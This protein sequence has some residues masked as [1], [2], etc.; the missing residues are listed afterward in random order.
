MVLSLRADI[1][2]PS[3]ITPDLLMHITSVFE[4]ANSDVTTG[5]KLSR[6]RCDAFLQR[7][8]ANQ[9]KIELT[10]KRESSEYFRTMQMRGDLFLASNSLESRMGLLMIR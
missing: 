8:F 2:S 4:A 10:K 6:R 1:L 3:L 7:I 9:K 5:T